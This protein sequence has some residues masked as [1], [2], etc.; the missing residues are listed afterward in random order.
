VRDATSDVG[1]RFRHAQRRVE[2]VGIVG[3]AS[4]I[5]VTLATRDDPELFQVDPLADA[6]SMFNLA[7]GILAAIV[8]LASGIGFG[9]AALLA[10]GAVAA[11]AR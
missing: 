9:L 11:V 1:H 3:F 5:L 6:W 10:I 2:R 8:L 4:A 7:W